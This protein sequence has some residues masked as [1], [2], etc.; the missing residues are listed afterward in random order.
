MD[1]ARLGDCFHQTL[2]PGGWRSASEPGQIP[3]ERRENFRGGIKPGVK[4]VGVDDLRAAFEVLE[5]HADRPKKGASMETRGGFPRATAQLPIHMVLPA[6]PQ[7]GHRFRGVG[8]CLDPADH[9]LVSDRSGMDDP[10]CP[11]Q[12]Q[13]EVEFQDF[14]SPKGRDPCAAM[15]LDPTQRGVHQQA[16]H[17]GPAMGRVDRQK[18][19][20]VGGVIRSEGKRLVGK[21]F[22]ERKRVGAG[23]GDADE[24]AQ[25]AAALRHQVDVFFIQGI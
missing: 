2:A 15:G 21:I 13:A 14:L 20:L 18:A 6:F 19:H 12:T 25:L 4:H 16:G 9:Q 23:W 17:L 10:S 5:V 7:A 1:S 3:G 22:R 11:F 24:T 8:Q